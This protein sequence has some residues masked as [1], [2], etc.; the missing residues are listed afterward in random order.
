MVIKFVDLFTRLFPKGKAW[1]ENQIN[2]TY[3]KN[4][5]SDEFGR[6]YDKITAFY[7]NF[8]LLNSYELSN[9]HALD[10]LLNVNIF[11]KRE[12]QH[13]IVEY[14]YG[15]YEFRDL[16]ED[17]ANF[18]GINLT[19]LKPTPAFKFGRSK[20]GDKFGID[21]VEPNMQIFIEFDVDATCDHYRKIVYLVMFFKPPY[22]Q[23][24]FS[25]Q[26]LSSYDVFKFGKSKFGTQFKTIVP[27][28]LD[29]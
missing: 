1:D 6:I 26:P 3:L 5:L 12:L 17:F 4:G 7:Q 2:I 14:I 25:A 8:N 18:I 10:Y 20:F 15:N 24:D 21:G 16:I 13:I 29:F 28:T 11:N 23:V 27:C 22:L 19:Y 9:F